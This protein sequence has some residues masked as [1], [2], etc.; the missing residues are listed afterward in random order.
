L[1]NCA[2]FGVTAVKTGGA[3]PTY[4]TCLT[5]VASPP[6][7]CTTTTYN[8]SA[9]VNIT[10][11]TRDYRIPSGSALIGAGTV[12]SINAA[13]DIVGTPRGATNDVGCWQYKAPALA[14]KS[15]NV[16]QAVNRAST[17]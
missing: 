12:D 13:F 9:F 6:S 16:N 7:G 8:T 15:R 14:F 17:Y 4:T 11:A 1:Q 3:T 10:N 2:F 5:N